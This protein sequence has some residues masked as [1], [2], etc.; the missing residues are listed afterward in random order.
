M[1]FCK[2]CGNE[3]SETAKFCNKCGVGLVEKMLESGSN[4]ENAEVNLINYSQEKNS[5]EFL[6]YR[7]SG[8]I[9][10]FRYSIM[11]LLAIPAVYY[12][13]EFYEQMTLWFINNLLP[14]DVP[15]EALSRAIAKL[16]SHGIKGLIVGLIIVLFPIIITLLALLFIFSFI[17][18]FGQS[19][20]HILDF[21]VGIF[22]S[23]FCFMVSNN[24][25]VNTIFDG[26]IGIIFLSIPLISF[27]GNHYYC[28]NCNKDYKNTEFY[29]ISNLKDKEFLSYLVRQGIKNE[30]KYTENEILDESQS[31][32]FFQCNRYSCPNCKS[33]IINVKKCQKNIDNKGNVKIK[34]LNDVAKNIIV[35]Y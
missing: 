27:I 31:D 7:E 35:Q 18:N 26:L 21:I 32:V 6:K 15:T 3:V 24:F 4:I 22:L 1:P 14:S 11:V 34:V 29:L 16:L 5:E 17:S 23:G 2:Y 25:E 19:R 10:L 20:N 8:K 33:M 12:L 9:N 28:E 13:G 30:K